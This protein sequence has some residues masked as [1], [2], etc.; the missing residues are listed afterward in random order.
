MTIFLAKDGLENHLGEIEDRLLVV[1]KIQKIVSVS[2]KK[3]LASSIVQALIGLG[4]SEMKNIFFLALNKM[5]ESNLEHVLENLRLSK[6]MTEA[7]SSK[8]GGF[9]TPKGLRY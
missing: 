2:C 4:I 7:E 3:E 1:D 9:I 5:A 6:T 8:R